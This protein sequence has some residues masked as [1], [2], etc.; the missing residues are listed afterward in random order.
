MLTRNER[1]IAAALTYL[2]ISGLYL[3][4][5]LLPAQS[6]TA[7][8]TPKQVYQDRCSA[9]HN[10]YDPAAQ[11]LTMTQW[12]ATVNRMLDRHGASAEIT[13]AETQTILTYLATFAVPETSRQSSSRGRARRIDNSDVWAA[14][15]T[16]SRVY[17]FGAD[18]ALAPTLQPASNGI[19]WKILSA[20]KAQ[21]LA[22]RAKDK[23]VGPDLLL[24]PTPTATPASPSGGLRLEAVF[25]PS[26]IVNG[27]TTPLSFGLVF[28]DQMV[29]SR[30]E[31][32]VV[33]YTAKL[34]TVDII[35]TDGKTT[36]VLGSK[37]LDASRAVALG[38][39]T[40][41]TL[42]VDVIGSRVK[43]WLDYDKVLDIILTQAPSETRAGVWTGS[44]ASVKSLAV[45]CYPG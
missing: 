15:P 11:A 33:R 22:L 36:Q 4:H 28:G 35:A 20:D 17:L 21:Q 6:Q 37:S 43:T 29:G 3:C 18:G 30:T 42:R 41:H 5:S 31:Y 32:D 38:G 26:P 7:P 27:S 10:A 16:Y 34:N 12:R 9:C 23:V 24:M 45:D 44:R 1:L 2:G 40:S 19:A 14:A 13:P 39:E 25:S 8:E